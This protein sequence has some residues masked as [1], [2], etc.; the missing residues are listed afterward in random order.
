MY[1]VFEQPDLKAEFTFT[2]TAPAHW[3]VVPTPHSRAGG[4]EGGRGTVG[5]HA[6]RA[7]PS[8][9]TAIVAGPYDVVRDVAASRRGDVPLAIYCRKSL[10]Q[11]LD[12][13][14]I[15]ELTKRGFAFF[16]AEFDCE[17]P[18]RK[19]DQLFTPEYNMGPWRTPGA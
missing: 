5:V 13:D 4:R 6:D 3:Q 14:N 9:I 1:P 12:A 18:F 15:F 19:Y 10:T 17:Y 7:D 8:Y 2:V 16:E 11:Y